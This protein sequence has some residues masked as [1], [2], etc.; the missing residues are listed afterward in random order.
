MSPNEPDVSLAYIHLLNALGSSQAVFVEEHKRFEKS[1]A[2]MLR[3]DH[4]QTFAHRILCNVKEVIEGELKKI[5]E[6]NGPTPIFFNLNESQNNI[7]KMHR[8]IYMI[9]VGDITDAMVPRMGV[10]Q[11]KYDRIV[12]WYAQHDI[13]MLKRDIIIACVVDVE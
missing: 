9:D 3:S 6:F 10:V 11:S 12:K 7:C 13:L 4:P 2:N 8:K 1:V 5:C